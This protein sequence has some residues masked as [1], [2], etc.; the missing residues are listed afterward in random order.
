MKEFSII[1]MD[2]AYE[3]E[4]VIQVEEP[5]GISATPII[6]RE[7][8]CLLGSAT[9][10]TNHWDRGCIYITK[11]LLYDN[12]AHGPLTV[13]TLHLIKARSPA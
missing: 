9:N 13:A 10:H 12:Q 2:G 7:Y 5:V 6:R 3:G 8:T 1:E 4:Q 11:A